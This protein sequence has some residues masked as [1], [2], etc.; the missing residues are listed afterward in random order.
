MVVSC[1]I[2][3]NSSGSVPAELLVVSRV[4]SPRVFVCFQSRKL[5]WN[6]EKKKTI[7]IFILLSLLLLALIYSFHT[8]LLDPVSSHSVC[9]KL[10]YY[11]MVMFCFYFYIH[12]CYGRGDCPRR[13]PQ[14]LLPL[15]KKSSE[16]LKNKRKRKLWKPWKKQR[17]HGWRN[18]RNRSVRK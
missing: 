10:L 8:R 12:S 18:L 9:Q 13:E 16:N 3:S 2:I 11:T 7:I 5:L 1:Q 15:G 4:I 14:K 6:W 17:K